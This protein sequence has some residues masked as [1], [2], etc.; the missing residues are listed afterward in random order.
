MG[1]REKGIGKEITR[2]S[3][4][5]SVKECV[6]LRPIDFTQIELSFQFYKEQCLEN[7]ER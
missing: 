4:Q 2:N 3:K 6:W 7:K 5:S 1:L